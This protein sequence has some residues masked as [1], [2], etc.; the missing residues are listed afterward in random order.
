MHNLPSNKNA[1]E[2]P[3]LIL[4]SLNKTETVCT[5]NGKPEGTGDA[6]LSCGPAIS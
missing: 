5:D 1:W 3:I 6:T 4:L 2:T